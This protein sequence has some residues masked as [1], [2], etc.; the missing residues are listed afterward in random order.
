MIAATGRALRTALREADTVAHVGGGQFALLLNDASGSL[1]VRSA[2]QRCIIELERE[3]GEPKGHV[4]GAVGLVARMPPHLAQ[5]VLIAQ[6]RTA[7]ERALTRTTS[8]VTNSDD[9][10]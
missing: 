10:A 4:Q 3:L 9:W 2:A 6:G 5:T 8:E 7:Y 1:G